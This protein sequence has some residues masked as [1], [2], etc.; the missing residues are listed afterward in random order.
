M[1]SEKST[2]SLS[3]MPLL[4]IADSHD[5]DSRTPLLEC[6]NARNAVVLANAEAPAVISTSGSQSFCDPERHAMDRSPTSPSAD[7]KAFFSPTSLKPRTTPPQTPPA[8]RLSTDTLAAPNSAAG[9]GASNSTMRSPYQPYRPPSTV[10]LTVPS[11]GSS[12]PSGPPSRS[13]S[14]VSAPALQ[15]KIFPTKRALNRLIPMKNNE[16][17]LSRCFLNT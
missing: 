17:K 2:T 12:G 16:P 6:A 9:A 3:V 5:I 13:P 14:A 10:S 7:S 4:Q 1:R 15:G 8:I 11:P